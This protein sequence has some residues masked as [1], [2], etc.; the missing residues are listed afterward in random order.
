[1]ESLKKSRDFKR[2]I[3]GGNREIMET[4]TIYRL[5]NQAGKTRAGISVSKKAGGSVKRNLIRRRI[6]EA[7][8][9]NAPLLPAGEDMVFVARRAIVRASY[10]DIE[11]DIRKTGGGRRS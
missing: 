9:R 7:I 3:E 11:R 6:K 4:V 8:R 5:P 10:G 1:V 2:V